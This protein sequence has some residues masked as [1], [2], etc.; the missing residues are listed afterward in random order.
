MLSDNEYH[1]GGYDKYFN[2]TFYWLN[3]EQFNYINYTNW[4]SGEPNGGQYYYDQNRFPA[5]IEG[6]LIGM[7]LRNT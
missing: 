6:H 1:I 2:E 5:G 3:G 7:M 4:A